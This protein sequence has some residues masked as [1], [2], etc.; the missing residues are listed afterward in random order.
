MDA[1]PIVPPLFRGTKNTTLHELQTHDRSRATDN[2]E[3]GRWLATTEHVDFSSLNNSDRDYFQRH[4]ASPDRETL[5]GRPVK[6]RSGGQWII[7]ASRR[8]NHPDGSFA[9]VALTT[10][11]VDY[12]SQFYEQ[13]DIGPNGAVSLLS[14]DGIMLARSSDDGTYV[15]RDMS[16]SPLFRNLLDRPAASA[17][18]FKSPVDGMQRLSYYKLSNRYPLVVL[19]TAAQDDVLPSWR[20]EALARMAFVLGL[21]VLIAIIGFYLVRQL[22]ERQSMAAALVAK[23]ADF[24]LLAEQS[25]DMVMRIGLDERILYVSAS[26]MRIVGWDP[27]QL[28]GTPALAG[29]NAEDLPRV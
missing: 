24:R 6:G 3:T 10:I 19:S 12:F 20:H 22:H 2:D 26:C 16:N 21:T 23:E 5:I 9:G 18:Y 25:S 15:G 7:T 14:A 28:A 8:F 11:N 27:G 1:V 17:Y 29:V 4:R 13:F